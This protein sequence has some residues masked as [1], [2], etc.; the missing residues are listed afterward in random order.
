MSL[1]TSIR[2]KLRGS[3][4]SVDEEGREARVAYLDV[5]IIPRNPLHVGQ[6]VRI[7]SLKSCDELF[8]SEEETTTQYYTAEDMGIWGTITRIRA[9]EEEL[10]EFVLKNNNIPSA[11]TYAH[12]TVPRRE[13]LTVTIPAWRRWMGAVLAKPAK[14]TRTITIEDDATIFKDT[15]TLNFAAPLSVGGSVRRDSRR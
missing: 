14:A 10:V 5:P 8:P 1:P 15:T 4:P 6:R 9:E 7:F 12:L 2:A 13:G 3:A 11:T